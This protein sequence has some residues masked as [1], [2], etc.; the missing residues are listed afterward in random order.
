MKIIS[1][2]T[3]SQIDCSD[4]LVLITWIWVQLK[5][6]TVSLSHEIV[7]SMYS[8][9]LKSKSTDS[10]SIDKPSNTTTPKT[11]SWF[12]MYKRNIPTY[13]RFHTACRFI[14]SRFKGTIVSKNTV[15]FEKLLTIEAS[16]RW[17]SLLV[18]GGLK[19]S[20][21]IFKGTKASENFWSFESFSPNDFEHFLEES[22]ISNRK[23][24]K[25][26]FTRNLVV[27]SYFR[28]F[29]DS[30]IF[31]DFHWLSLFLGSNS[32]FSSRVTQVR[33]RKHTCNRTH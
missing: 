7:R 28:D 29:I 13:T 12:F 11:Y 15:I 30:L 8:K 27:T 2:C 5:L 21:R 10:N 19:S 31:I 18:A 32:D 24:S 22:K 23:F 6:K 3:I 14:P 33:N 1:P 20:R 16:N 9:R 25:N 26:R 17:Y 4:W